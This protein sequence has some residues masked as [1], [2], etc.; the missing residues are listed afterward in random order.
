MGKIQKMETNY[1]EVGSRESN[2][3]AKAR[4]KKKINHARK[5]ISQITQLG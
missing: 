4:N 5:T 3:W 1:V 2:I